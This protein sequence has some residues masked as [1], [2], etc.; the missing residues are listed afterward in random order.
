MTNETPST[1]HIATNKGQTNGQTD[2]TFL[3]PDGLHVVLKVTNG[4]DL[5]CQQSFTGIRRDVKRAMVGISVDDANVAPVRRIRGREIPYSKWPPTIG[6]PRLRRK[7]GGRLQPLTA[8]G[9]FPFG[10]V[11]PL[12]CPYSSFA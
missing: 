6:R 5:L 1:G 12:G 2:N 7:R 4:L 3:V 8:L 10:T 11:F 9:V